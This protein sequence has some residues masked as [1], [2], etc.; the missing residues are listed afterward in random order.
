L[1]K[2]SLVSTSQDS[3]GRLSQPFKDQ[4]DPVKIHDLADDAIISVDQSQAIVLFN[5]AAE[6]MFGYS[7]QWIHRKPVS[8]LLPGDLGR[9]HLLAL[10]SHI[11]VRAEM[12]GLRRDGTQFPAEVSIP[13]LGIPGGPMFTITLRD[14][15]ERALADERLRASLREKEVLLKEIH[16]RVKNNLQ[17]VS[18]LLRLQSRTLAD[19]ATKRV[20]EG[21]RHRIHSMA[22]LHETLYQSDDLVRFDFSSY[23]NRLTGQLFGS[24]RTSRRVE[25]RIDLE[26]L[27]LYPDAAVPCGLIVNELVSNSLKYAF[28]GSRR[29]VIRVKSR[30]E[31]RGQVELEVSDDG[32]GLPQDLDWLTTRTLGLRLVRTLVEQIHGTIALDSVGGASF[33]IC[34]PST[35]PNSA[36]GSSAEGQRA[37]HA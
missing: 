20:F 25:L 7:A 22:L 32:V 9:L 18:S 15:T 1:K 19:P 30:D 10:A 5:H 8:M 34:F 28:P 37:L 13:R 14:V 17:L 3:A 26:K 11:G 29:G 23:V 35:D 31:G 4:G 24:Y 27:P 21:S 2:S 33:R 16:H 12:H 6:K 36:E